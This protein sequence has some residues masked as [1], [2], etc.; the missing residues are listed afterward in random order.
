MD[1]I[2]ARTA[3]KLSFDVRQQEI[4]VGSLLGDG[5]LVKTT[6]GYAFRVNHGLA[7]KAYV[8]WKYAELEQFVCSKPRQSGKCY[9]FRTVSHPYLD[10]LRASFYDGTTKIVPAQIADWMSP[11]VLAIW[12]MDDGSR[13][14][15]QI[16]INSQSF[17]LKENQHLVSILKAKFGISATINRDKDKFRLRVNATS[18]QFMKQLVVPYVIP[19]MHYKLSL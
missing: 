16:R 12:L 4:V 14:G 1:T 19:S 6:R 2:K 8:D 18:M 7:Q 11:M 5:Y 15:N 9:Y 13:E 17:S 10:I 3:R